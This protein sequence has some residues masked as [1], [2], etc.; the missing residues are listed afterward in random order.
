M[1]RRIQRHFMR[2][3]VPEAEA[4]ELLNEVIVKFIFSTP[5]GDHA[6]SPIKLLWTI[7]HHELIDWARRKNRVGRG[8]AANGAAIEVHAIDEVWALLMDTTNP[9]F[10][11]PGWVRECVHRAAAMLQHDKPLVAS[12]LMFYVHGYS[13][14]ELAAF[15][16]DIA[17]D[18]VTT[19]QERAAKVRV[20]S[21]CAVAREYFQGCK[22]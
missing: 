5:A 2:N 19:L 7:V 9:V 15:I 17:A 22:E 11:L 8:K 20:H 14:R 13:H 18:K 1:G 21:Y 16:D 4:E 12:I 3:H 6:L 10:D